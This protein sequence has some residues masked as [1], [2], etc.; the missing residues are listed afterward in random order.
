GLS[1]YQHVKEKT[2]KAIAASFSVKNPH[3]L[4]VKTA[5]ALF[6]LKVEP[7]VSYGISVLW[8]HLTLRDFTCMEKAKTSYLKRCLRV[9][10]STRNRLVYELC[11][12]FPLP[13][14]IRQKFK[15]DITPDYAQFLQVFLQK[16]EEISPEFYETPAM[17]NTVWTQANHKDR[18]VLTRHA[19]HGFHF[20]ICSQQQFHERAGEGCHCTLCNGSNIGVYHLMQCTAN[21]RSLRDWA[22][23]FLNCIL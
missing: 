20:K 4:S 16:R 14:D 7:I 11:D 1:F 9:C 22:I 10:K 18:H 5:L 17:T 2:A 23:A 8:K 13:V 3:L 21:H 6:E 12:T 15:L 19:S